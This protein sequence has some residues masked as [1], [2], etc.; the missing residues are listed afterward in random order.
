MEKNFKKKVAFVVAMVACFMLVLAVTPVKELSY[1]YL[2]DSGDSCLTAAVLSLVFSLWGA[3]TSVKR[4]LIGVIPFYFGMGWAFGVVT[5]LA[6]GLMLI[7]ARLMAADDVIRDFILGPLK[8]EKEVDNLALV[9]YLKEA[10]VE[11]EYKEKVE[12]IYG[13]PGDIIYEFYGNTSLRE[14]KTEEN[15]PKFTSIAIRRHECLVK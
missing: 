14:C 12:Y 15:L 3:V 8:P 1:D 5:L 6:A 13:N 10:G 9:N 11:V 2:P 4:L 7:V